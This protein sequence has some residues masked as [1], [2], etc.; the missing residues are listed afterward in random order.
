MLQVKIQNGDEME[1]TFYVN[2]L[3]DLKRVQDNILEDFQRVLNQDKTDEKIELERILDASDFDN[4][5]DLIEWMHE[6][7]EIKDCLDSSGYDSIDEMTEKIDD[8]SEA[9]SEIYN[10]SRD[11]Y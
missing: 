7:K 3:L 4:A 5:D 9:L 10:I 11:Y 6:V 2:D 8:M 1:R